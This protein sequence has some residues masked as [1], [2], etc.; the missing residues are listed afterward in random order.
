MSK[1]RTHTH[2]ERDRDRDRDRQR[3]TT[4]TEVKITLERVSDTA[5]LFNPPHCANPSFVIG[6][7]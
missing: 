6:K 4:C 7:F 2:R 3:E 1:T 5:F